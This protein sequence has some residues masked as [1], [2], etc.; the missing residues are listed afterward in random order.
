LLVAAIN[1]PVSLVKTVRK[2]LAT[3]QKE[4][5]DLKV[6]TIALAYDIGLFYI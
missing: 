3:A 1:K 6:Q 2:D 4:L 5:E